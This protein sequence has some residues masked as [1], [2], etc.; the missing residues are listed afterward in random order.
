MLHQIHQNLHSSFFIL[1]LLFT[2]GIPPPSKPATPSRAAAQPHSNFLRTIVYAPFYLIMLFHLNNPLN[3]SNLVYKGQF[4]TKP[5]R[6]ELAI[7]IIYLYP[8]RPPPPFVL[9]A[10]VTSCAAKPPA[11]ELTADPPYLVTYGGA[12]CGSEE[13]IIDLLILVIPMI[14][15]VALI[16]SISTLYLFNMKIYLVLSCLVLSILYFR[17]GK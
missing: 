2:S 8:H 7:L 17:D 15:I 12:T 5:A 6:T 9:S 16:F 1:P 4:Q 13:K 3:R 14:L 10:T 11:A